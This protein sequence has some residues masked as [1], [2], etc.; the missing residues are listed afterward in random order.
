MTPPRAASVA[1]ETS[2]AARRAGEQSDIVVT[3]TRI[4]T[5][6]T[7]DGHFNDEPYRTVE[8]VTG[9]IQQEPREGD[10][11]TEQTQVWVLFDSETLYI[12]AKCFDSQPTREVINELRRDSQNIFQNEN[13]AVVLD[14]F[15][16]L[17][18]AFKFQTNPIGAVS[19]SQVVDTLN[20][21]SWNTIWDVHSGRY[22]WGWG[23]EIAIPF[24]SLRYRGAG[25]QVWGINFRRVIKWK[26]EIAYLTPVPAAYGGQGIHYL[27]SAA[28]LVG[29]ETPQQS[30]NLEFKPYVVSSTTTERVDTA[31]FDRDIS[32]D[33]GL[34]VKYGLT[35]G[36]ILDGTVNTDFAHVEEDQQQV[37]LTRFSLFFPEKRDFF[38]EGQ[39]IF[40]FGGVAFTQ[41]LNPG[42][43]PV[44]FFSR[45]IGLSQGQSVPVVAG[46]RLTGRSG[47]YQI[48]VVNIQTDDRPSAGAVAT[49]FTAVRVK[50][51]ILRRSNVGVIATRRSPAAGGDDNLAVGL[52]ANLFLFQNVSAHAYYARTE[53][54]GRTSGQDSYRGRFEYAGDRYG[55]TAEHLLVGPRFNPEVG[56]V[57]R[58]DVRRSFAEAR[59]SP[60]PRDARRVRRYSFTGSVAYIT[61]ADATT[62]Q[63]RE[64]RGSFGTEYQNGDSLSFQYGR[65]Y[66]LLPADFAIDPA[67][68]VPAGGYHSQNLSAQYS[69][70]RQRRVSG[71]ISVGYGA[72]YGGT[73]TEAGYSG[74]VA[75]AP[76]FAVEPSI[77]L[78]W[79]RL[80]YG[81]FEAP[82]ITSRIIFTPNAR[83]AISSLIQYNGSSDTLSSSVRLR[84]EYRGGSELFLVY[85]DGRNTLTVGYPNLLNRSL[86][87]KVTRLLRF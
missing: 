77:S 42:D 38:L 15:H 78:N 48:G 16:D 73:K 64:V 55:W 18:N 56:Y 45:R 28:T 68:T 12:S 61:D 1:P 47:R 17:R 85:S 44:L 27:S 32:G 54:A 14:T 26:N 51:D 62:L 36:L 76:Q 49:N 30:M 9:F 75:F 29:L 53:S 34:D 4:S 2:G 69:L 19:D 50:R 86:A 79:V 40:A 82:V 81:N 66:E 20:N 72:L 13:F 65:T 83:T 22:D 41:N 59:F 11:A 5:P 21:E 57:R 39:G 58:T 31:S 52:D 43:V 23:V 8:P 67:A 24:K 74:R 46:A 84:W 87:L 10:P 25:S 70:G 6:I 80:P 63:E 71:N 33:V 7:L 3:A 60:R 35:R 37:N